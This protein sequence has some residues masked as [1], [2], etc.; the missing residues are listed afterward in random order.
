MKAW[1]HDL[2]LA[3]KE[4]YSTKLRLKSRQNNHLYWAG[5][6]V[7]SAGI[8]TNDRALFDWGID[9]YRE[10]V[11]DIRDDGALPLELDRRTRAAGYHMF[12]LQ[13]LIML[14]EAGEANGIDMYGY[15]DHRLKRL[16]DLNIAALDDMDAIGKL[17]GYK[18]QDLYTETALSWMEPYYARFHD[19]RVV[20]WLE[21]YRPMGS[22]RTGG[23]MTALYFPFQPVKK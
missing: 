19:K 10:A 22:R 8:V 12:A 4:D 16:I 3:A 15:Q 20:P 18:Q 7:A 9:R 23:N 13:P 6:G 17:N 14:A 21:K 2:A 11:S 5:W 1:I